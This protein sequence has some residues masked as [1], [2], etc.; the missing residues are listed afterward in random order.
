MPNPYNGYYRRCHLSDVIEYIHRGDELMS[1]QDGTPEERHDKA[2]DALEKHWDSLEAKIKCTQ[3][4]AMGDML[5]EFYDKLDDHIRDKE[6]ADFAM[7][8]LAG[9]T[10]CNQ[11]RNTSDMMYTAW[12]PLK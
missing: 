6:D 8:F 12:M 10:L 5:E 9:F 1:F 7:G 11:I 3:P 2:I 4:E